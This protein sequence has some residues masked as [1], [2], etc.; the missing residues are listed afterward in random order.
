MKKK[1][2]LS[3]VGLITILFGLGLF[4]QGVNYYQN[5]YAA[6]IAYTKVPDQIPKKVVTKDDSGKV[7]PNSYSYNYTF[8][9]VLTDGSQRKLDFALS[10]STVK[11]YQPGAYLQANISKTRVVY[12]PEVVNKNKVP[13]DLQELLDKIGG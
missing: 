13:R 1:V 3:A 2:A 10:G 12:G 5:T 4:Y 11:A 9:F 7:V 6:Q 8:T